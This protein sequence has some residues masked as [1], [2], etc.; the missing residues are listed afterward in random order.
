[1]VLEARDRGLYTAITDCGAGGFSSA[2]GEMGEA[3]GAVVWLDRVPL[4]Y[5]GLSYTEIWISEAQ[6]R[7]ILAVPPEKWPELESLCRSEDVEAIAIGEF[8]ATGRLQLFFQEHKVA[9]LA[10]EFVHNGRPPI[11]REA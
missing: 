6:E 3:I 7:M 9:D 1:V 5:A 2:I 10:M 11:V 4:K 8:R